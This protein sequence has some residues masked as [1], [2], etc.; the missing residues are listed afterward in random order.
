MNSKGGFKLSSL[1]SHFSSRKQFTLIELLV[2]IAIISILAGMLLPA[3][4]GVRDSGKSI[5]CANNQGQLGK[6]LGIYFADYDYFPWQGAIG[7]AVN[8]QNIFMIGG[9]PDT[10]LAPYINYRMSGA[11]RIGG[12]EQYFSNNTFAKSRFLCPSVTEGNLDYTREEGRDVNKPTIGATARTFLSLSVNTWL[13]NS[14]NRNTSQG[15]SYGVRISK[16]KKLTNLVIFADGSGTG[17]ASNYCR[18]AS[19]QTS[20][21]KSANLPGRH[22]GGGNFLYGDLHLGYLKWE[23]Y[24]AT[25]YG[26]D[27]DIYWVPQD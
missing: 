17:R 21:Q 18:W 15:K 4:S 11:S 1:I 22:K 19:G 6:I 26:Y 20:D 25:G 5:S 23:E 3:L 27:K 12:M 10:P 14:Y 2:V 7:T 8:P 13:C 16:T 24:P 9:N